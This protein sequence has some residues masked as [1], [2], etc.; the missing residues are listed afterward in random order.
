MDDLFAIMSRNGVAHQAT[1]NGM[2]ELFGGR[3]NWPFIEKDVKNMNA[4]QAREGRDGDLGKL[5]QFFRECKVNNDFGQALLQD[6]TIESFKWL[7]ETFKNYMVG[8]QPYFE[9]EWK[10][11]VDECG[12]TDNPA[13]IVLWEKRKSWIVTYF[14]GMYCGRMTSTQ[15]SESKNKVLNDGYVNNSTTLHMFAK[16]VIDS[17]HHTDHMDAGETHYS[18]VFYSQ[19]ITN[20][21]CCYRVYTRALYQEYKKQYGNSTTFA[22]EPNPDLE[23]RNGRASGELQA[24]GAIQNVGAAAST[25]ECTAVEP[26][27]ESNLDPTSTNYLAGISLAE[28][29]VSRTKGRKFGKE[30][31]SAKKSKEAGNPYST[32]TRSYGRKVC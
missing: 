20:H 6:E 23:V 32:Y 19:K 7:F 25:L 31:Q 22:I 15:R 10:K 26:E 18:Q 29:P 12:M 14:K 9:V 28:P 5:F 17:L 2:S 1:M 16:R 24:I 21:S 11:L 3:Q 4:E 30:S 27:H 8:H 13:I